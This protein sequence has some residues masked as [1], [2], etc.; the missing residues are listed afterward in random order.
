MAKKKSAIDFEQSLQTLEQLV[1]SMEG[2]DLTLEKS[3][4][5]FEQGI[6][7][8]KECQQALREAEQKVEILLNQNG[9]EQLA[10]FAEE[11]PGDDAE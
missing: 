1:E 6:K 3:L 2:G 5:A 9:E 8:T 4:E 7:L 10:P 11:Q